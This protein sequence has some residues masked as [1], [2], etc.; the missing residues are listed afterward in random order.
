MLDA[1]V[2]G[3][4]INRSVLSSTVITMKRIGIIGGTSPE[5]TL[6]Y[7]RKYIE[8]S[9]ERFGPYSFP[10]LVVYSMNFQEFRENPEGWKGR[11]QM[12]INAAKALERA[13]AEVIGISANT[14]HLVF[15]DVQKAVGARMVSI[16]DAVAREAEK[17][18]LRR[19]LL[20]GT[21]TTTTMRLYRDVLEGRGFEV[22]VPS[23]GEVDEIDRIIFEELMFENLESKPWLL[24]LI[25]RYSRGEGI[26][27]VILGCTEL[28]LAVKAGDVDVDV[29][30]TAEIH[31]RAL[32]EAATE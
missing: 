8:I 11:K 12:L 19:L 7:Y 18:G 15:P 17:K 24:D 10:E 14:P 23:D 29:L 30:D 16:I 27:A 4:V 5:S 22:V 26:E 6:Y 25:D 21:K 13:G 1:Y 20:L 32:I 3:E 28:P 31:M 9:R 2:S